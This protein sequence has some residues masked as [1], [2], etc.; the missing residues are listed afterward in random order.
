MSDRFKP[1]RPAAGTVTTGFRPLADDTGWDRQPI[2]RIV[3]ITR[4]AE[5]RLHRQGH[6]WHNDLE[7]LRRFGRAV[8]ANT[9]S[10]KVLIT[11]S[12]GDVVEDLPVAPPEARHSAWDSWGGLAL[13][14]TPPVRKAKVAEAKPVA[15]P[16]PDVHVA[17]E[18][19]STPASEAPQ[20]LATPPMAA[21]AAATPPRDIPKLPVDQAAG[22]PSP[23][24]E[25]EATLP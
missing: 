8:A 25:H 4:D 15:M 2:Y 20:A 13:P 11:N 24:P 23:V 19:A 16:I 5:G 6:V 22:I 12:H 17:P 3:E 10:H 7:M 1:Q 21:A 14:P 18:P 9:S